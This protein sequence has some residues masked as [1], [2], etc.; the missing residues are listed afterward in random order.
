MLRHIVLFSWKEDTPQEKITE[1]ETAFRDL[2]NKIS[3][4]KDF[5]WG[6]DE[7]PEGLSHGFTHCFVVTFASR[8]DRDSYL[9]HP[10][11]RK[12]VELAQP[13]LEDSLVVDF[14]NA[15]KK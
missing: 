7:S 9:P 8:E 4:I 11:H 10:E 3:L 6:I 5:E 13:F 15:Y 1:I 14:W 12:F 2:K